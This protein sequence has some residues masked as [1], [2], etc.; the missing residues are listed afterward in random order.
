MHENR[1]KPGAFSWNELMT[2]DVACDHL[3]ETV[4]SRTSLHCPRGGAGGGADSGAAQAV[5][6]NNAPLQG[7]AASG[8]S[9]KRRLGGVSVCLV[10]RRPSGR[11]QELPM[12]FEGLPRE[13]RPERG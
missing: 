13:E 2:T 1:M 5:F 6:V 10:M 4:N 7:R 3:P 8:A 11:K 9:L 12:A